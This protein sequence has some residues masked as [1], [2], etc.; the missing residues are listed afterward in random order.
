VSRQ[1]RREPEN[2]GPVSWGVNPG[3]RAFFMC[4]RAH[5]TAATAFRCYDGSMKPEELE[6]EL[7][8]YVSL[9]DAVRMTGYS[10]TYLRMLVDAGKV[11]SIRTAGR[12]MIHGDDVV[13]LK[14]RRKRA[15][16]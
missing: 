1:H 4:G 14:R 13:R 16:R 10:L 9:M 2:T 12:R 5:V 6:R 11:H 8:A 7:A 15:K 3:S